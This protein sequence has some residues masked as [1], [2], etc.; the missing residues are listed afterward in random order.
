[1]RNPFKKEYIR[2]EMLDVRLKE[3][4]ILKDYEIL[5]VTTDAAGKYTVGIFKPI[6]K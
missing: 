2:V 5:G 4:K 6:K 3:A 1:M